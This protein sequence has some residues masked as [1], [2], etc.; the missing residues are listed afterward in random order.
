MFVCVERREG[1]EER[2][3]RVG[4]V[5][6]FDGKSISLSQVFFREYQVTYT[7]SL[8]AHK[9]RKDIREL[10][11]TIVESEKMNGSYETVMKVLLNGPLA[12]ES[13]WQTKIAAMKSMLMW[14]E[15]DQKASAASMVETVPVVTEL[16][17]STKSNV[18]KL[19]TEVMTKLCSCIGNP[20]L[21][22]FTPLL[23]CITLSLFYSLSTS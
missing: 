16:M 7:I 22:P 1:G 21:E 6:V 15:K 4:E 8:Q 23:V 14:C 20:D 10:A 19:A 17:W 9:K 11:S 13:K 5:V 2:R 12:K 18:S 3:G